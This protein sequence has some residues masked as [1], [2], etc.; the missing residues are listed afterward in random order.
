MNRSLTL[1]SSVAGAV[2]VAL[3]GTVLTVAR[4]AMQHDLHASLAQAQWTG[5]GYLVAVASLLVFAGRLGDRH[6]HRRTFAVGMLGFGV[7]SAALTVAPGV[8]WVTGLRVVQGAFGALLQPA[9][10]GMLRAS[11]PP[12]RLRTPIAVR[13]AAIGVAAAVGPMVGGV[14]TTGFGWR[15]VFLVN[16]VPALL[17]GALALASRE[18]PRPS[19]DGPLGLPGALLLAVALACL[20]H[21]LVTL[22][23]MTWSAPVALLAAVAFVQHERRTPAPLLPWAAALGR[24]GGVA[25]RSH[26]VGAAL[27][28]LVVASAALNGAVFACVYLLQDGL[29][30]TPL[31]SALLSLPL[32]VFLVAAAPAAAVLLRRAGARTTLTGAT[33]V[34]AVGLLVLAGATGPA[35]FCA[36][37]A[38]VGAG[39]GA[40]MVAATHV[41]VREAP[42]ESA[43]V[44]GGLQQTAMNVG[45]ALGVAAATVLMN[46]GAARSPLLAVACASAAAPAL[47]R[48]LPGRARPAPT[49]RPTACPAGHPAEGSDATHKDHGAERGP[50]ARS[51][52]DDE[53]G[54]RP[55][56]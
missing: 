27:G 2:I 43:G 44:A 38:L 17:F 42:A 34:L 49:A 36:G 56:G 7:V 12:E 19:A 52:R 8:D 10:L 35:V 30:L 32:A 50:H 9:T 54:G 18:E 37:F 5:T 21:T 26:G 15:S 23:G 20:V 13:T 6:G 11:F 47:C 39:F 28:L 46:L 24:T 29:G 3:D 1:A 45:P 41:V 48:A 51:L 53:V 22:P 16:V 55:G 25:A 4:P 14:L 31:R 40:T 33:T